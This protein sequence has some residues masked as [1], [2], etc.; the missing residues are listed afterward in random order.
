MYDA[1]R[2]FGDSIRRCAGVDALYICELEGGLFHRN[3]NAISSFLLVHRIKTERPRCGV[4]GVVYICVSLDDILYSLCA[5]SV[6]HHITLIIYIYIY[7]LGMIATLVP[8]Y[9]VFIYIFMHFMYIYIKKSFVRQ[10]NR[11]EKFSI[12]NIPRINFKSY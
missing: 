8:V 12:N 10:G 3:A 1:I 4:V 11:I 6:A 9:K 5:S 7:I 2:S